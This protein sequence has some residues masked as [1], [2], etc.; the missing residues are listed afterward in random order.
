M[1]IRSIIFFEF[2]PAWCRFVLEI[3]RI[4]QLLFVLFQNGLH[5]QHRVLVV[6]RLLRS[7]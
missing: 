1:K 5:P 2:L 4:S 3:R 7:F 6:V